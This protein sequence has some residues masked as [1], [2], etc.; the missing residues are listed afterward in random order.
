MDSA[1]LEGTAYRVLLIKIYIGWHIISMPLFSSI[2]WC[3]LCKMFVILT[4]LSY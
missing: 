2:L 4:S 1:Q 3:K